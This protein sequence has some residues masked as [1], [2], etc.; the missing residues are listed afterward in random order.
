MAD[1][2]DFY[3]V[4]GVPKTASDDE[5]K[6]AYRKL[7]RKFHPDL[8]KSDSKAEVK[9]K[10]VQ[11]AY[12]LLSDAKKRSAYDQYGHAG[13]NSAAAAEA[14]AAAAQ[15]GRGSG[16]FRYAP[17]TPG[18]ATVDF[19]EVDLNDLFENFMGGKGRGGARRG[20]RRSG[21]PFGGSVE[22]NG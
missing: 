15:A 13:V 11:E 4:L 16:G 9:F 18:G 17:E 3:E 1:K 2:R 5:I 14:A 10:E 19:G 7:A 20:G 21:N 22:P 8:N 12:D 6:K